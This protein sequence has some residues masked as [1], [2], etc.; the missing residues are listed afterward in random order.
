MRSCAPLFVLVSLAT[1]VA[2][3]D[4][5]KPPIPLTEREMVAL[6]REIQQ[7]YEIGIEY[8]GPSTL[9]CSVGGEATVTS[10]YD[11]GWTED[12]LWAKGH[13]TIVPTDCEVDVVSDTLTLNGK[14]DVQYTVEIW[15]VFDDDFQFVRGGGRVVFEGAVTWRRPNSDTDTC[16]VDLT[17]ES[18]EF[19]DNGNPKGDFRGRMCGLDLVID[20]DE[21]F[22]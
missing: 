2:S 21:L 3:C 11:R 5:T 1:G 16:S 4:S 22:P 14:P 13:R 10:T 17:S 20:P 6:L 9:D 18:T 15:N 12:S 7:L 19:D 8:R